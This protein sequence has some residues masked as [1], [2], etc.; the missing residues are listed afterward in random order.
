MNREVVLD[1]ETTGLSPVTG[2]RVVEIGAVELLNHIPT[3]RNLHI[4]L[5]PE[6]DMPEEAFRV[7]GLSAEFLADKPKFA[8][9][10]DEFL[11]FID[12]ATLVIH[13]APFD[14]GFLNHELDRIGRPSLRNEV[15][16][17]VMVARQRHPGA[18]VSL[19]A[20]CKHYGIDNSKR[21][22]HG[23]LLDSE[24][25]ADVYLEL[26]GGRQT[27]LALVAETHVER[28]TTIQY[29]PARQR[30]TPL[31]RRISAEEIEAHLKFIAGFGDDALWK[32]YEDKVEAAE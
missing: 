5:N 22:L 25:L 10:A 29:A 15:I 17:T 12:D 28:G 23:A 6:R 16:D 7:H 13:N 2:D 26:I 30:S 19:D 3:G 31:A 20:L 4:Y 18:R 8:E 11:E 24:I 1:T 27:G 9:K 21:V 32:Y 14:M